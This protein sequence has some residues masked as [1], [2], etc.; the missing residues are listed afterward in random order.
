ME[1]KPSLFTVC[2]G[3]GAL[4]ALAVIVLSLVLFLLDL[5]QNRSLQYL[6]YLILIAGIILV[7]INY[8]N[9]Y[10]NGFIE[11]GKAFT[12][13]MLSSLVLAVIV[14]IY[15]FVFFKYINPGAMEEIM[16]QAE[17][18]MMDRGMT[19]ME[20]EQGMAMAEKMQTP[21]WYTTFAVL[22]NFI[23]GIVISLITAIF[24][25]REDRNFGEQSEIN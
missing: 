13:G 3:Y 1:N 19:D 24:V 14:G 6:S 5:D 25:K 8:R 12:V 2:I 22:G 23:I 9:K 16:V 10:S 21:G 15:T 11:Y 20:I 7:Q 17:Q 4:I 18:R